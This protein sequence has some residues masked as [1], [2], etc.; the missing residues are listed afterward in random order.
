LAGSELTSRLGLRGLVEK[1]IYHGTKLGTEAVTGRIAYARRDAAN[2]H[3]L[4][5]T[6]P[7]DVFDIRPTEEQGLIVAT[8]RRFAEE[9]LRPAAR[10][11]DDAAAAPRE[12]LDQAHAL[13]LAGLAV[14]EALGGVATS[15]SAIAGTLIAEELGRGDMG[16]ATA[17]L[18]PVA[19]VQAIVSWGT[20]DQQRHYLP[21]FLGDHFVPAA[22][23]LLEPQP[24]FDPM[25]PHAGAV[26]SNDG[27]WELWGQKSLVPLAATAEFFLVAAR[28]LGTGVRLFVVPRD[29]P[30]L[31]I[32]P[33][34][35]MGVR[36]AGLGR[37]RLERARVAGDAVLGG[38][39]PAEPF[40]F[41]EVVD[42]AR[43][44]CAAM[45]VGVAQAVLDYVVP[46][47]NARIAF[48][49]PISNRQAVAFLVADIAIELEGMRLL[50]HRAASR[51]D[52][53][54]EVARD[55]ALARLQCSER[56]MKIGSDGV[57]LLGGHG[58]VKEHP[59]E[60]WYRDL[61]ALGVLEGTLLV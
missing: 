59:V 48:G 33:E 13:G 23:A 32:D 24:L 37:L 46:Y 57:Q 14:P 40:D 21:L 43:I 55:A 29:A 47:T 34:P 7:T 19:V 10:A 38:E 12:L 20:A 39:S 15:R 60:R 31:T 16:L 52:L 28:V 56:G 6:Q 22:L 25:Q 53:G 36:A 49:E 2:A 8:M 61:R 1:A 54:K 17:I 18:S 45:G 58:F 26:R 44:A 51:V 30:G 50:V 4:G 35:A 3:R 27:G 41:G 9:I 42:R 5:P 11:A